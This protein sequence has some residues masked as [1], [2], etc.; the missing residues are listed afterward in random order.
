VL[1]KSTMLS[2]VRVVTNGH[3]ITPK[4]GTVRSVRSGEPADLKN[5]LDYPVEAV[6]LVSGQPI[7]TERWL[8]AEWRHIA[9][10]P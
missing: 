6:C 4:P 7:R 8:L 2:A 5:P 10:E 9:P 3:D 1:Y